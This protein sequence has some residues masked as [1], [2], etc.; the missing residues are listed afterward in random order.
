MKVFDNLWVRSEEKDSLDLLISV[1]TMTFGEY[2]RLV[3][4]HHL[5]FTFTRAECILFHQTFT[6]AQRLVMLNLGSQDIASS[7]DFADDVFRS[8]IQAGQ[9]GAG[10]TVKEMTAFV[11]GLL[12]EKGYVKS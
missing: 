5:R 9:A 4:R 10:G 1:E 12:K 6:K 8:F 11:A 2:L 3:F 7:D